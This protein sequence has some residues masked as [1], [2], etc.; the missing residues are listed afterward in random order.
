MNK[1]AADFNET[2]EVVRDQRA[3]LFGRR[4][5]PSHAFA[6]P[7]LILGALADGEWQNIAA[8]CATL[9]LPSD[10]GIIRYAVK[11]LADADLIER[12]SEPST[13]SR[14]GFTYLYRRKANG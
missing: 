3:E 13:R 10:D 6:L 12:K 9:R 7:P 8:I 2:L 11:R 5:S 1:L 14:T 4:Y